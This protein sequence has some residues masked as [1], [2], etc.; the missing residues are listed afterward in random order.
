MD[1][2]GLIAAIEWQA[3]EYEDRTGIKCEFDSSLEEIELDKDCSTAVFRILQETL[4]N[5]VR[6]AK[7]TKVEIRV[8]ESESNLILRIKDNGWGIRERDISNPRSLGLLGMRERALM[9]G[10]EL[11]ISGVHGKGTTV[12][13]SIPLI[14]D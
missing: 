5:V 12:I 8:E 10:G 14:K 7:A 11:K 4:T 6:H 3:K 13:V 1:D 9:F 2:L